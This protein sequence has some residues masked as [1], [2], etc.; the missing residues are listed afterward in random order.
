MEQKTLK[1]NI[2]ST[3]KQKDKHPGDEKESLLEKGTQLPIGNVANIGGN[4]GTGYRG[5]SGTEPSDQNQ[6]HKTGDERQHTQTE[7]DIYDTSDERHGGGMGK[8]LSGTRV[9]GESSQEK[10]SNKG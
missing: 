1:F 8:G 7:G 2:M 5:R 9:Q 4:Q 10:G 3:E 6:A